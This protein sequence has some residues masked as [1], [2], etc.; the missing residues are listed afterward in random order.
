[1]RRPGKKTRFFARE[2]FFRKYIDRVRSLFRLSSRRRRIFCV[3]AS[4]VGPPRISL[5]GELTDT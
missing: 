5:D 1:M 3:A 2:F 4:D